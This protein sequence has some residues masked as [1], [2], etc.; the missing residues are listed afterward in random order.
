LRGIPITK[1]REAG[2]AKKRL[3][4][5]T[6]IDGELIPGEIDGFVIHQ[7]AKDG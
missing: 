6:F 5:E 1:A 3:H 7:R 2:T 4:V